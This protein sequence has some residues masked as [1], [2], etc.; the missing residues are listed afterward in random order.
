MGERIA[1]TVPRKNRIKRRA[2]PEVTAVHIL[3]VSYAGIYVRSERRGKN[4]PND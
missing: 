1:F 2:V 4:I 3:E